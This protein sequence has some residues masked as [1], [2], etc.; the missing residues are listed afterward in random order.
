MSNISVSITCYGRG[1]PFRAL[2]GRGC[3]QSVCP[4][5]VV[6]GS[7]FLPI[8]PENSEPV[9]AGLG[10]RASWTTIFAML[11]VLVPF[12]YSDKGQDIVLS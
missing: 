3:R 1:S 7:W 9:I 11:S 5:R 4:G 6:S 8:D 2:P 10:C 12:A